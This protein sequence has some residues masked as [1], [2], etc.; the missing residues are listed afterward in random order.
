M[1]QSQGRSVGTSK[2]SRDMTK[3]RIGRNNSCKVPVYQWEHA[4]C[5]HISIESI[6]FGLIKIGLNY[7]EKIC[8][9]SI[10]LEKGTVYD[11][12]IFI[13][14]V[15]YSGRDSIRAAS[16]LSFET[17]WKLGDAKHLTK[18]TREWFQK[19]LFKVYFLYLELI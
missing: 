16:G 8:S 12:D 13:P 9:S 4:Y 10:L 19:K 14:T 3:T 15:M 11:H 5:L 1:S 2:C 6:L 18:S 7:F 17:L